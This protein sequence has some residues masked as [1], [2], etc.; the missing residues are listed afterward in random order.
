MNAAVPRRG[1]RRSVLLVLAAFAVGSGCV[2]GGQ[3]MRW[4]EEALSADK[5][6]ADTDWRR[7][8]DEWVLWVLEWSGETS[9]PAKGARTALVCRFHRLT[10]AARPKLAKMRFAEP[11][12]LAPDELIATDEIVVVHSDVGLESFRRTL[13]RD[14]PLGV[15]F[16]RVEIRDGGRVVWTPGLP[17][18][19]RLRG[20]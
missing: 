8:R 7:D 12:L 18:E 19:V 11:L 17:C 6:P 15:W 3:P 1:L 10:K 16:L 4:P 2:C 9:T 13:D 20:E 5:S 14:G